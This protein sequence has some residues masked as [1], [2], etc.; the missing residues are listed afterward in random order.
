MS[1]IV[2][3][4]GLRLELLLFLLLLLLLLLLF[5]CCC[6]WD[7]CFRGSFVEASDVILCNL[8]VV[9]RGSIGGKNAAQL[10]LDRS[11]MDSNAIMV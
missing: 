2:L 1:A 4:F 5:P 6:C 9:V 3:Y 10:L 8:L 11:M 7:C